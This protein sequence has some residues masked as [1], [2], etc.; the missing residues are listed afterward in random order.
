MTK[1]IRFGAAGVALFAAMGMSTAAFA[2]DDTATATAT[3]EV[4]DAL[5]LDNTNGLDFGTMVVDGGGTVTLGADGVLDCSAGDIV[6]SG[7][8]AV[9]AFDV[10][11]TA[12]KAVTINLPTDSIDL[13]HPDFSGS[14]VGE[15]TIELD[16]F[17]SSASG[18]EITLDG[19][20]EGDFTVG[21]TITFDGSEVAGIY[22]GSFDVS[23]EY[24]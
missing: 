24:S 13:N 8:S 5:T 23:V 16:A 17:T 20:G 2:Q 6:C 11:G 4:L 22:S 21:G 12:N 14:S 7:T 15:H 19:S 3:A 18:N 9:A 1:M 10:T